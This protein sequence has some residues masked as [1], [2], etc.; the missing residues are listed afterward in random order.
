MSTTTIRLP[1]DLKKR[2]AT[3][4]SNAATTV[5]NFILQAIAEKTSQEELKHDFYEVADQRYANILASGKTIPWNEMRDYLKSRAKGKTS[6]ARPT[7]KKMVR[8]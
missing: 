6:V 5:H 3:A 1:E 7:A 4:A 8:R 2:V